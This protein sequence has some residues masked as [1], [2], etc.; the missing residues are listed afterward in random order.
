MTSR[1]VYERFVDQLTGALE[2]RLLSVP[3]EDRLD[4]GT[5]EDL[6]VAIEEGESVTSAPGCM[7]SSCD[8]RSDRPATWVRSIQTR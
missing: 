8:P 6:A 3:G 7:P 1:D 2:A 4:V 5:L